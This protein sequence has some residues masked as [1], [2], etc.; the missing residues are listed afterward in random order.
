MKMAARK[1][2]KMLGPNWKMHFQDDY[3]FGM[4][5][6]KALQLSQIILKYVTILSAK[7]DFEKS[8][9]TRS[10]SRFVFCFVFLNTRAKYSFLCWN[11]PEKTC[12]E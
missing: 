2:I 1:N 11:L 3:M 8:R 6:L 5:Q 9:G 4:R 10:R 12:M 7:F